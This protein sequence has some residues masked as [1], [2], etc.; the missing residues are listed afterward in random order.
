MEKKHNA[1]PIARLEQ[2]IPALASILETLDGVPAFDLWG[3]EAS[4]T[5]LV[6]VDLVNGFTR[7]GPL[8]SPRVDA[9]VPGIVD[10][11]LTCARLGID[12]IAF[13]DSHTDASPEFGAYPPHCLAG[14][15]EAALVDELAAVGGFMVMPKNSTNGFLEP[16]FQ[17][18]LQDNPE[19]D[20]FIV[21][22]DCTDICVQQFAITLNTWFNRFNRASRVIVPQK[23]VDTYDAGLHDGDLVHA[24]ALFN[25]MTNGVEV[26]R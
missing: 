15:R 13:C 25:M 22:G 23:L 1:M 10:F 3:I 11:A 17:T 2:M 18:W 21:T 8:A 14:T 16:V 19:K 20:T 5:V 6:V 9:L 24:M 26:V 12:R 4:R 7:E